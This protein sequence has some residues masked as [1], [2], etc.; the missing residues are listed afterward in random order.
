MPASIKYLAGSKRPGTQNS[1]ETRA[2]RRAIQPQIDK[3]RD[4]NPLKPDDMCPLGNGEVLMGRD[5]QVDHVILFKDLWKD[6]K[7]ENNHTNVKTNY[8]YDIFDHEFVKQE[9]L[10]SWRTYHQNHATLRWLSKTGKS[11]SLWKK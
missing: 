1:H 7:K 5:A 9:D 3:F 4:M 10:Q 8:N 11:E 6:W 2:A